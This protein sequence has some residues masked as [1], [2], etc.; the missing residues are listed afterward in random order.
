MKTSDA[1][2]AV[3]EWGNTTARLWALRLLALAIALGLW[4]GV[5]LSQR[6]VIA[7]K[8]VE[9]TVSYIKPEGLLLL[10]PPSNV[11][12][13]ITGPQRDIRTLA[14]YLVQVQV[15]LEDAVAGLAQVSLSRDDVTLPQPELEV[16]SIEPSVISVE[17]DRKLTKSLPLEA[18]FIGEP[19]AGAR[20]L[21]DQVEIEPPTAEVTGP[22]RILAPVEQLALS[23]ISLDGHAIQFAHVATVLTPDPLVQVTRNPRVTVIIPMDLGPGGP[24]N[25]GEAGGP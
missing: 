1:I 3:N 17:L 10:N 23:P 20:V 5:S 24:R 7:E 12:V 19:A 8:L 15:N 11:R 2:K 14:P 18:S 22:A 16:A 21:L 25:D 9:A 4:F 6:D 13:R